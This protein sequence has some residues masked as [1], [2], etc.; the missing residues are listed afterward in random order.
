MRA[1][2]DH[3]LEIITVIWMAIALSIAVAEAQVKEVDG[4]WGWGHKVKPTEIDFTVEVLHNDIENLVGVNRHGE[5]TGLV[6]GPPKL[7]AAFVN[8]QDKLV[9]F[10]CLQFSRPDETYTIPAAI[11]NDGT[12]LSACGG[13]FAFIRRKGGS[14]YQFSVPG[15]S[16]TDSYGMNDFE[17]TV[18]EYYNPITP[19]MNSGWERSHG[20]LRKSDGQVTILAAPPLPDDLGR[21]RSLTRTVAYGVNKRGQVI[22][23]RETIFTPSNQPGL[24]SGFLYDNGQFSDLPEQALPVAIN[25][26]GTIL[27]QRP[28]GQYVL[29][30]DGKIYTIA[31]PAGFK[32]PW[33]KGITDKGELFGQIRTSDNLNVPSVN[34]I[35]TPN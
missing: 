4:A 5:M 29:Y 20:F 11:N 17:D 26:D 30:D 6:P 19:T 23:T 15:A 7:R 24:W 35:A 25:N 31:F 34:F 1:L 33:I 28:T 14:G 21:P 9:M 12:T 3:W 13:T 16:G 18:G 22:G 2:R 8:R 27:A 10:D 32:W